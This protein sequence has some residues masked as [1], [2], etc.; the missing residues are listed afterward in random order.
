M[1]PLLLTASTEPEAAAAGVE[2]AQHTQEASSGIFGALGI[3]AELLILQ[4]IAFL[5]LVWALS[6][7]VYPVFMKA[8]DKRQAEMEAGLKASQEAQKAAE[9]AEQRVQKQLAAA[10]KQADD[11]LAATNKE[12]AAL[13][14]D[15]EA[16]AARRAEH[17]VSEA[18]ADMHNQLQ[19]AREE[20]KAETRSLVAQA[21]EAIIGEK[22]DAAK[23]A[24]LVTK[25][26]A[27]VKKSDT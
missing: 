15:A 22:L 13:L 18:K 5:L 23:D 12:A 25:A 8:L 7:W 10:R 19:A 1:T 24:A 27:G 11:I 6:K 17:I 3:N 26:L 20:L 21:T 16:K 14:A 2:T 4:G 9:D